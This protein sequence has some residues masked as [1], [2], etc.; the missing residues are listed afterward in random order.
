MP[1]Y[2]IFDPTTE[3]W[4]AFAIFVISFVFIL[5]RNVTIY[6]VSLAAAALLILLGIISPEVAFLQWDTW[7]V[8]ALYWGYG[9]LAIVF[10]ESKVPALIANYVLARLKKEKYAL[11]FICALAAFLSSFMANPV[12][13][14]MLAPLAIEIAERLKASLFLYLVGLAIASNVVTTV[15]MVADPPATILAMETGLTFLE[16]YWFQGKL[17]LGTLSLVGV[18]VAL[19]TLLFQFRPLNNVVD[20]RE[21]KVEITLG[22]LMVFILSVVALAFL[23]LMFVALRH[24]AFVLA[25]GV[26]VGLASLYIGRENI[27]AMNKEFDWDTIWFLIGIFVVIGAV[28]HVGLLR[29]FS[30]WLTGTGLKSPTAYL[31]ILTW[32]SV[33]ISAFVDNVPYTILMIPVCSYLAESLGISPWPLYFGMLVGTGIGGNITPV[34]ATANVL[35][36]GMLEKRGYRIELWRY[37]KISLPFS[38]AAVLSV[39]LLI[40]WIWL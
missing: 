12:I 34:G 16:F 23:P 32:M 22:P 21:E 38:V 36:C 13:V 19:L 24:A 25:V 39:H 29:D 14:I 11:L 37:M 4:L 8:L 18:A 20:I 3:K 9:M 5:Y 15:S 26:A 30:N 7:A 27:A 33:L 1:W 28:E 40:Q 10:R 31:A 2:H 17:G 6:Y 35:A